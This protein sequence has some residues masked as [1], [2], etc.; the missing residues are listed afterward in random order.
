MINFFLGLFA[1]GWIV[2][3]SMFIGKG[4]FEFEYQIDYVHDF[5]VTFAFLGVIILISILLSGHYL[6][7]HPKPDPR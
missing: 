1:L 3:I 5:A 7:N 6:N 2:V 4:T